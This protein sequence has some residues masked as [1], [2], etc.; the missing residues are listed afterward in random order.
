MRN[1][2]TEVSFPVFMNLVTEVSFPGLS[3]NL[4]T[5]MSLLACSR[6][7][8]RSNSTSNLPLALTGPGTLNLPLASISILKLSSSSETFSYSKNFEITVSIYLVTAMSSIA[9]CKY[10]V[11]TTSPFYYARNLAAARSSPMVWRNF[12]TVM[13]FSERY[14]VTAISSSACSRNL[15]TVTSFSARNFVTLMSS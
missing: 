1:L 4:V 14:F 6:T 2:V 3:R 8:P 11:T 12:V 7:L 10:L 13:S 15:V 9:C 5:V